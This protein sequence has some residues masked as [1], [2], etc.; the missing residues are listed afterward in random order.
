MTRITVAL[1]LTLVSFSA[2]N[3]G[4]S[5]LANI[6]SVT[7]SDWKLED[8]AKSTG[9]TISGKTVSDHEFGMLKHSNICDD[10][11]LYLIWSTD[12]PD[13]WDL[14]GKRLN[15]VANFDGTSVDLP[16]EVVSIKPTSRARNLVILAHLFPNSDM[17]SLIGRS[18]QVTVSM[19]ED[20]IYGAYFD[21][22]Q[23]T[24][25]LRGFREARAQAQWACDRKSS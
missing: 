17:I 3:A 14:P 5:D 25:T 7:E 8:I 6:Q 2:T 19:A 16:L 23:D 12:T 20:S 21:V 9:F 22:A 4:V 18:Y 24:F 13:V 11:E 15:I 10:D 1:L